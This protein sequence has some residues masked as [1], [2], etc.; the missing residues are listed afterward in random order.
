MQS[1]PEFKPGAKQATG[2]MVAECARKYV[3]APYRDFGRHAALGFDCIGLPVR[4]GHDLGIL[5]GQTPTYTPTPKGRLAE[6]AADRNMRLLWTRE[7]WGT[8]HVNWK[9]QPETRIM[10]EGAVG[11]FIYAHRSEPQHFAIFGR[12][13]DYEGMVTLIH[14]HST[15]KRVVE[16]SM[17]EFWTS[18]LVKVYG[19]P[20]VAG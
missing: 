2:H 10:C 7:G 8:D 14:A 3:G 4:V 20:N 12:H 18:R 5:S 1:E 6:Q 17:D 13:P 16:A 9:Q 19:L 11:L 15:Y